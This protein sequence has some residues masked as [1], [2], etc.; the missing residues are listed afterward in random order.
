MQLTELN[1]SQRNLYRTK[2]VQDMAKQIDANQNSLIA[3]PYFLKSTMFVYWIVI[4]SAF[5][6]ALF[7]LDAEKKPK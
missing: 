2:K 1:I 5:V 4:N 6:L 3:E 7:L